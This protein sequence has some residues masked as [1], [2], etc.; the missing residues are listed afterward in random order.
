MFRVSAQWHRFPESRGGRKSR[1]S[2]ERSESVNVLARRARGVQKDA[3]VVASEGGCM[4]ECRLRV[5]TAALLLLVLAFAAAGSRESIRPPKNEQASAVRSSNYEDLI[6]LF[7]DW[8]AFQKPRLVDGVP[9]YTASA[10]AAQQRELATYQRRLAAIDRA[11]GR[12]ASRW[13]G[14]SCGPR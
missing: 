7:K 5:S 8:R 4:T 2:S 3:V 14:T 10:M 6:N 11:A 13:T 9:D 12:S 1:G